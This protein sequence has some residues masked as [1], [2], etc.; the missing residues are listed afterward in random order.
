MKKEENKNI[1]EDIK[2]KRKL[3]SH[4]EIGE[5]VLVLA[6]RLRRKDAIEKLYKN[7]TENKPFLKRSKYLQLECNKRY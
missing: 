1:E 3:K 2:A 7:T 4:L 5:L 6:K